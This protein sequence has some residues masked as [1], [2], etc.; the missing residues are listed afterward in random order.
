[1]KSSASSGLFQKS[2]DKVFSSLLDIS[3]SLAGMS[4]IPP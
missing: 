4:K 3:I 2:G 1:M